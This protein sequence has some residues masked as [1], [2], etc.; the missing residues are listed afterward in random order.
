[1]TLTPEQKIIGRRNFLKAAATLPAAGA[2]AYQAYQVGPVPAA[3]VG[4]GIQGRILIGNTDPKYIALHGVYDIRPD[5]RSN[6][7]IEA[8]KAG[9]KPKTM[10]QSYEEVLNDS[11]VEA[12]LIATPLHTHGPLA[13]EALRAG[14][15]VFVE[16]TM[17]YSID[18]C[19]EMIR[20]ADQNRLNLQIGHQRFYNPLYWD[21]YKMI[22]DGLLGDVYHIR[23]MWHRNTDW[24]YW[25]KVFEYS[26]DQ[27]IKRLR[28]IDP[29]PFGYPDLQH[30]INWRWYREYSK[31]L[32]SELCS[33]QIAITNWL[34]QSAPLA[35]SATS[36][37]AKN[38]DNQ[39]ELYWQ[40]KEEFQ[41]KKKYN[42]TAANDFNEFLLMKKGYAQDD[43]TIDDHIFAMYE[44]PN[45]RV[46]TYSAIQSSS[47]D[48][49]Y[50]Q[51]MGTRGTLVLANENET[52]LFWEPGWDEESAKA[53]SGKDRAT[54]I[55]LVSDTANQS[56]FAAHVSAEA[57]GK[58]GA[59]NM[60]PYDPYRWE[61]QG[62]AHTIRTGAP[63][64]SDGRRGMESAIACY[65][66]EESART[67][68]RIAL[69]APLA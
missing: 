63:N 20:L 16:K 38:A 65:A 28:S 21:A 62:F 24:N 4:T 14:K 17:A 10:Y 69:A 64:L 47:V 37:K 2:V 55:D 27:L 30:L 57:K 8:S 31:G 46:V 50:E 67:K 19:K 1:M 54:Q 40:Y 35:V 49:Y 36:V 66:G 26:S 3:F 34:F 23:A 44:Y 56:A 42:D 52:Y 7:L 13:I 41:I 43:R 6:A 33:H 61:L 12:V 32:W 53:A 5:S 59:T 22:H 9:H 45:N 39:N 15:H 25:E 29:A 11:A 68:Q 60:S 58:G 18:E 48:A 51:I